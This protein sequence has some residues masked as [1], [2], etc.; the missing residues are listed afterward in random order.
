VRAE[1]FEAVELRIADLFGGSTRT[2]DSAPAAATLQR[3]GRT[4]GDKS[5]TVAPVHG[6]HDLSD[7]TTP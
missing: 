7:T 3:L 1:P 6:P 2:H 5:P 4:P